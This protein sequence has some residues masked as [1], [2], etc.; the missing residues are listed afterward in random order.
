MKQGWGKKA[1]FTID[2]ILK[3]RKKLQIEWK[4]ENFGAHTFLCDDARQPEWQL[5]RRA[6]PSVRMMRFWTEISSLTMSVYTFFCSPLSPLHCFP[7]KILLYVNSHAKLHPQQTLKNGTINNNPSRG[8]FCLRKK[9][10]SHD[11]SCLFFV[12]LFVKPG[13][14]KYEVH[15]L[16]R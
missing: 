6:P 15:F 9:A 12:C 11:D 5:R 14:A 4:G 2:G 3:I 16:E 8:I 1:C 7:L 13:G 10:S